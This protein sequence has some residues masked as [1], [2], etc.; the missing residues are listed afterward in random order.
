MNNKHHN[1]QRAHGT[2]MA[3]IKSIA[4]EYGASLIIIVNVN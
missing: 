2:I 1:I 4:N 3:T